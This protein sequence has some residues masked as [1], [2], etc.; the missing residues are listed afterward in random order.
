MASLSFTYCME[1]ICG[2]Y[3]LPYLT[4]GFTGLIM[5][6]PSDQEYHPTSPQNLSRTFS[7]AG[8]GIDSKKQ[9]PDLLCILDIYHC[10]YHLKATARLALAR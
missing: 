4:A 9:P 8:T 10:N 6:S 5:T 3:L 2:W 1:E 7:A